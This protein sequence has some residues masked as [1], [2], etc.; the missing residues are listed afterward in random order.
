MGG[1][2]YYESVARQMRLASVCRNY[3]MKCKHGASESGAFELCVT[4][5]RILPFLRSMHVYLSKNVCG[6]TSLRP[7]PIDTKGIECV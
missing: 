7:W 2:L 4:R 5:S 1:V 3:V 6:S